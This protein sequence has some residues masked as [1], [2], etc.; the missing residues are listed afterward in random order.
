MSRILAVL[1]AVI[2]ATPGHTQ[3]VGGQVCYFSGGPNHTPQHT[4]YYPMT[5]APWTGVTAPAATTG[6]W[7]G[8]SGCAGDGLRVGIM[9][10]ACNDPDCVSVSP[11][12]T[13]Q[14]IYTIPHVNANRT[15]TV[16][17]DVR[18]VSRVTPWQV[19]QTVFFWIALYDYTRGR[20]VW[21]SVILWDS[22]GS[23][24]FGMPGVIF[25][26]QAGGGTDA[27]NVIGLLAGGYSRYVTQTGGLMS[28]NAAGG[29]FQFKITPQNMAAALTDIA[30]LDPTYSTN[31]ADYTVTAASVDF[32]AFRQGG[33]PDF[34]GLVVNS[35]SLT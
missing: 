6:P 4:P 28:D 9:S 29:V 13:A 7:Y 32:E 19:A 15:W 30:R 23:A 1:V 34:C 24:V 10:H 14:I 5:V 16:T 21:Y 11:I 2:L 27:M 3:A 26:R 22:R 17:T 25:D 8:S 20:H 35:M 18:I 12:R 31:P 33:G